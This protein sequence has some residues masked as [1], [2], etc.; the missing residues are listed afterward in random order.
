MNNKFS[1]ARGVSNQIDSTKRKTIDVGFYK[2]M[3]SRIQKAASS[4]KN[5]C[6]SLFVDML[7]VVNYYQEE[8]ALQSN[9]AHQSLQRK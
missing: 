5:R 8:I 6:F 2:S 4:S 7:Q 1:C 9:R 3:S